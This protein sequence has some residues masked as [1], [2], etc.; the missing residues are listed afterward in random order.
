MT[1]RAA[2]MGAAAL[3]PIIL[4]RAQN[5]PAAF[6]QLPMTL[7]VPFS[8]GGPVDL[9]GRLLA[10]EYQS[11]SGQ[12]T[13]VEN[14]MGGAGNIGI[15]AVLNAPPGVMMLLLVPAGNLTINPTLMPDLPFSV[16]HDF[17]P[18]GLLA[19]AP[20]IVVASPKLGIDSIAGL[21]AKAKGQTLSYGSPGVGSQLHLVM[22]LF[23]DAAGIDLVHVPYRGSSQALE[24]LLGEHIDLLVS[25]LP[26]VLPAI[27][28]KLVVPLAM[29][30]AQRVPFVPDIPTLAEA[31]IPGIDVTSW[32]GMLA[33]QAVSSETRDAIFTVT[34]DLL[35]APSVAEKLKAQGLSVT[36]E[37]PAELTAR[38][39]RETALWAGVIKAHNITLQR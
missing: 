13:I 2:L 1:R 23:R 12:R 5:L 26:A 24:D 15:E 29:T 8:P 10:P 31:G 9:L 11:R 4:A 3:S 18:V 28:Q 17:T 33:P 36:I 32:Y 30:S 37:S 16:E 21:I 27:D 20:N 25:N 7:V 38:I 39:R 19:S 6:P 22:E 34:K 14:K 35:M